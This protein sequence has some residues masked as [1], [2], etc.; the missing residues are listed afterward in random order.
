MAE[1]KRLIASHVEAARQYWPRLSVLP[2]TNFKSAVG[3]LLFGATIANVNVLLWTKHAD[4]ISEWMLVTIFGAELAFAGI[5]TWQHT[6]KRKTDPKYM[7]GQA[8]IE[9][10]KAGAPPATSVTNV[11]TEN[12]EQVNPNVAG[13]A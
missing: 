6:S 10:A 3:S 2:D 1:P 13:G 8:A 4:I 11:R 7:E 5:T 12:V 9:A